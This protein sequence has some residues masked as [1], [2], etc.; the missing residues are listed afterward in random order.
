MKAPAA[1]RPWT[2]SANA[3]SRSKPSPS[4][5]KYKHDGQEYE[6]N[7]IDTPGHVDFHYEVSRSL[8]VLRRRAAARRCLPRRRSADGRQRLR[9][10]RSK[11]SRSSRSSTRSTSSTPAS[12][13]SKKRSNTRSAIDADEVVGC[14]GK[15]GL[16]LRS[17]S[18]SRHR[19]H[20]AA[21]RR[22][23]SHRCKRWS[24]TPCTTTT[25]ARS[26]TSAS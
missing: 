17:C 3:A 19:A 2:S 10:D 8:D 15:T 7:L 24:S 12:T 23:E 9:R 14:S 11:T 20:A 22:S 25:A 13:K 18:R 6:L 4:S 26:P 16:E 5:M 1:R 21:D